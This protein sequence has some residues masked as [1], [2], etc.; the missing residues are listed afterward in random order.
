MRTF[1]VLPTHLLYLYAEKIT[2]RGRAIEVHLSIRL[3]HYYNL[4]ALSISSIISASFFLFQNIIS[5][6]L[7]QPGLIFIE[8][9]VLN[10][11]KTNNLN[12]IL[13]VKG[14]LQRNPEMDNEITRTPNFFVT[15]K[16]VVVEILTVGNTKHPSDRSGKNRSDGSVSCIIFVTSWIGFF[17]P[18]LEDYDIPVAS[19][20]GAYFVLQSVF[21]CLSLFSTIGW[22]NLLVVSRSQADIYLDSSTSKT[23]PAAQM[24]YGILICFTIGIT[25]IEGLNSLLDLICYQ[26]FLDYHYLCTVINRILETLFCI[27]QTLAL[28]FLTGSKFQNHLKVK[29]ILSVALL[30]DGVMWMYTSLRIAK[31]PQINRFMNDTST[32]AIISCYWN[33]SIYQNVLQP[34]RE[35]SLYIHLEYFTFCVGL[36]ASILPSS[37]ELPERQE[38]DTPE[39]EG[40]LRN[41]QYHDKIP[42]MMVSFYCLVSFLPVLL[43]LILKCWTR[44]SDFDYDEYLRPWWIFGIVTTMFPMIVIIFR[45]LHL[46]KDIAL[47]QGSSVCEKWIFKNSVIFIACFMGA[48]SCWM[49]DILFDRHYLSIAY[50]AVRLSEILQLYIQTMFLLILERISVKSYKKIRRIALY[51]STGNL[52]LWIYHGCITRTNILY[53]PEI[54][55]VIISLLT[56]YRFLSFIDFYRIYRLGKS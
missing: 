13:T 48:V 56:M 27:T 31:D 42:D 50:I 8:L 33:S 32:S 5:Y 18:V 38:G 36:T 41:R 49:F 47:T 30:T 1:L 4:Y 46:M 25:I 15:L 23:D 35:I 45:G 39:P 55:Q 10:F 40:S 22:V 6:L 28:I 17:F 2:Y 53:T 52:L 20:Y 19:N 14:K 3:S 44:P 34:T 12:Y 24:M 43:V 51:L 29:Y 11:P 54:N 9:L 16:N 21:G 26:K 37:L 7:E